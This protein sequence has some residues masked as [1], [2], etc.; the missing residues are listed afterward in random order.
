MTR[1]AQELLDEIKK[2]KHDRELAA[3]YQEDGETV[4]RRYCDAL[5]GF[6]DRFG[7]RPAEIYSSPGRTEICGNHCDHQ[8]GCVIAAC[9]NADLLAVISRREDTRICLHSEGYDPVTVDTSDAEMV[10]SEAGTV[11]ALIRGMAFERRKFTGK[12]VP[13]FDAYLTSR[14]PAGS[15]MSSS[16]AFEML[17]GLI[18]ETL[19]EGEKNLSEEALIRIAKM[20]QAAE[21]QYFGKPSGLMDQLACAAGGMQFFDFKDEDAPVLESLRSDPEAFGCQICLIDT[22][23]SHADLTEEYAQIPK[24]MK[25]AAQFF[26]KSVLREV[27]Y[28]QFCGELPSLRKTIGDRA[29]LRALHF[30]RETERTAQA[31][32]ALLQQDGK[33]FLQLEKESGASSSALLQNIVPLSHPEEQS[34]ALALALSDRI[35]AETGASRVHGGGFAGTIQAF[36][37]VERLAEYRRE[38]EAVFGEGSCILLK[39]R[40]TGICRVF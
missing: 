12:A 22:G 37:P 21:N 39:V 25:K 8:K 18:F 40:Q 4:R 5:Q 17:L 36:V 1:T 11:T 24:D 16:A 6:L 3:L 13:G 27:P 32:E 23:S 19:P 28:E 35:L 9:V 2:G 34:L 10:P 7:N 26:G 14:V 30:F 20:G 38:I 15:G 33:G 29:V 31:K